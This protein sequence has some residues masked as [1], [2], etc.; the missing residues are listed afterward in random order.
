MEHDLIDDLGD[1]QR[2]VDR[3]GHEFATLGRTFTGHLGV[4]YL[5]ILAP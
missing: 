5:A 4:P 3:V 2:P 1:E